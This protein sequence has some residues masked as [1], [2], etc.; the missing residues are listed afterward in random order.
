MFYKMRFQSCLRKK[1]VD[2]SVDVV[3]IDRL[4][5]SIEVDNSHNNMC[6]TIAMCALKFHITLSS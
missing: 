6:L 3:E 5:S 4:H 2:I 1:G